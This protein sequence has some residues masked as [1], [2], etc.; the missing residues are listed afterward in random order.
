MVEKKGKRGGG[1]VP[2]SDKNECIKVAIRCRPLN[3]KELA[4]GHVKICH[5]NK[6]RGEISLKREA[7]EPKQFTFDLTYGDESEQ[8]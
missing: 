6:A 3:D 8:G 4:Q 1:D 5:I 7:E 2:I